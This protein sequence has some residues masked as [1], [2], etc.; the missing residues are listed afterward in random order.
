MRASEVKDQ[1]ELR[2][3]VYEPAITATTINDDD[4]DDDGDDDDS[5]DAAPP[6]PFVTRRIKARALENKGWQRLDP[7]GGGWGLF[8]FHTIP[9]D[10]TEIVITEGEYDAM[11][12]Y[13]ATGRPA[14]SLPSG[15][16]NLPVEVLPMLE[17]FEKVY[18]WMDNDGPGQEGAEKF[19]SK[20][21]LKR[22]YIVKPTSLGERAPKDANE[23]LLAELDL[24][25]MLEQANLMQHEFILDFKDLRTQVL[26]EIFNPE[27]YSGVAVTSLP[28]FT[29]FIKGF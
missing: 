21:G 29:G 18:L 5:L 28:T 11:A 3:A 24:N 2:G 8:G 7:P 12:V 6:D 16:R 27:K 1:E 19:A 25:E 15:C 17:R 20:I 10:A 23:A 22:C 13:Q 26:H 9:L 4:D 14:V